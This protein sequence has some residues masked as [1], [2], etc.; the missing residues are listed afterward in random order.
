VEGEQVSAGELLVEPASGGRVRAGTVVRSGPMRIESDGQLL[1]GGNPLP[2]AVTVVPDGEGG[3]DVVN[4]VPLEPYVERVV[5]A[6]I[7]S[8]WP[9]E[10]LKAQVVVSRT[11]ALYERRRSRAAAFDLEG[12]ILSQR[13]SGGT[14]P[15]RIREAASAVRGEF[16]AYDGAPIL[17]AFHMAAGGRTAASEEVW[18]EALPYLRP[19]ASPDED[20]PE[21]FWSY[22][23]AVGDLRDAL[24]ESG[25]EPGGVEQVGVVERTPSGRVARVRLGGVVLSGTDLRR[26]LGGRGIKS[27]LFDAR[28]ADGQVRFLGSGAGHGVGL[29]QWGARQMATEGRTY[30]EIL[31]HYFPGARLRRLGDEGVPLA[32]RGPM[33]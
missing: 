16:L 10:S 13:Y 30:R 20:C 33:P 32:D 14:V 29:S 1:L 22:E 26:V 9:L 3:L 15:A 7:Y 23:I 6:E 25:L 12:S 21:H 11:Y 19:V 2:G 27:T 28:L 31:E 8:S 18:G 4:V 24:E 17:A 5:A